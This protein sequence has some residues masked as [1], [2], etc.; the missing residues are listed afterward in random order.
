MF[1]QQEYNYYVKK[2]FLKLV[3]PTALQVKVKLPVP[4]VAA[5]QVIFLS[6]LQIKEADGAISRIPF[7]LSPSC[8]TLSLPFIS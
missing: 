5:W 6:I 2:T 8:A 1:R 7:A 3:T 4:F